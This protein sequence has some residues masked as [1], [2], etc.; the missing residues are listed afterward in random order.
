[1]NGKT[2]LIIG[3]GPAGLTAAYELLSRTGITPLVIE[4]TNH[5][6]GIARTAVYRGNRLD[7]GGHR[8]FSKSDRVLDWWLRMLPLESSTGES[9]DSATRQDDRVMLVRKRLTRILYLKR[10]FGYPIKLD[11]R[12]LVDLGPI[13]V[14]KIALSYVKV[15]IF[16]VKPEKSLADFFINQFGKELYSTFFRDYTEKVWGVPCEQIKPDW[17]SQRVKRN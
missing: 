9:P 7:F 17:G 14:L 10:L 12:T 3:A 16:P 8:Y 6:G 1:M 4:K 15:R 11:A 2:A 13:R 5:V